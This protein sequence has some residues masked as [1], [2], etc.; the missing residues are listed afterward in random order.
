MRT[1]LE[2]LTI[3]GALLGGAVLM[4]L[5]VL[6]VGSILGRWLFDAPLTG[7]VELMQLGCV[8]ALA[9][10]LPYCQQR[11]GHVQVDFFTLRA[12]RR[13]QRALDRSGAALAAVIYLLLG[14][15]AAVALVDMR[16]AGETTMLLALPL[17]W[18]YLALVPALFLAAAVAL[19]GAWAGPAGNADPAADI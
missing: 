12:T 16:A 6:T 17:W 19:L 8:V 18:A 5:V 10:A 4:A 13:T 1:L 15:R 2:R 9:A 3:G 14:W 7:D 11:G